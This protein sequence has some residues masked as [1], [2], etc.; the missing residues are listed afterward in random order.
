MH[1]LHIDYT[2][3]KVGPLVNMMPSTRT[4]SAPPKAMMYTGRV[5]TGSLDS[6]TMKTVCGDS[7]LS[8]TLCEML[9]GC[10]TYLPGLITTSVQLLALSDLLSA[11][12]TSC[13]DPQTPPTVQLLVDELVQ[14]VAAPWSTIQVFPQLTATDREVLLKRRTKRTPKTEQRLAYIS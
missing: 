2:D 1:F 10:R 3:C 12:R 9:T 4:S 14:S 8:T 5:V 11:T 7:A 6:P 13:S